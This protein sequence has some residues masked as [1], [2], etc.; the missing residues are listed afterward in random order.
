VEEIE[1]KLQEQ[2]R[3]NELLQERIDLLKEKLIGCAATDSA[4]VDVSSFPSVHS[5]FLFI[6]K[7]FIL[8]LFVSPSF[9]FDEPLL[10]DI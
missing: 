3:H 1:S 8:F 2:Q 7:F 5:L 6:Y 4:A 10:L 9:T